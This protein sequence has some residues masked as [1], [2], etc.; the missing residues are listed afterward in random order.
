MDQV[1]KIK[2]SE[3]DFEFTYIHAV[4]IVGAIFTYVIDIVLGKLLIIMI[5]SFRS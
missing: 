1:I 2:G 3:V 4:F 5:W